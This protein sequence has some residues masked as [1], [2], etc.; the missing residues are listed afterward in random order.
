MKLRDKG[1]KNIKCG[2]EGKRRKYVIIFYIKGA[3]EIKYVL[4]WYGK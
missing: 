2:L 3:T 1:Q 4:N